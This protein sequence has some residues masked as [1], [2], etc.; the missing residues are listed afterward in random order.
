MGLGIP[1]RAGAA[2][3]LLSQNCGARV[4]RGFAGRISE[5]SEWHFAAH[6]RLAMHLTVVKA[7]RIQRYLRFNLINPPIG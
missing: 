7:H 6:A 1:A 3:A 5:S 2:K 4:L